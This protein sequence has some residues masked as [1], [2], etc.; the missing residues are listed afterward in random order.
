MN[1]TFNIYFLKFY[2]IQL[3]KFNINIFRYRKKN[4]ILILHLLISLLKF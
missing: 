3:F 2:L 4:Q 1:L